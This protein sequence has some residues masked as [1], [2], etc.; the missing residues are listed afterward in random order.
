VLPLLAVVPIFFRLNAPRERW[1][2]ATAL[3]LAPPLLVLL[4]LGLRNGLAADSYSPLGMNAGFVFF[5]GNN[6]LSSGRSAVYPPL[7]GELNIEGGGQPDAP[8]LAY[9][10]VAEQSSGRALSTA[11][12]N[13]FWRRKALDFIADHPGRFLALSGS[14]SWFV[15]HEHRRH[16]L[17][18]AERYEQR[19]RALR[20]PA[21]PLAIVWPLALFGLAVSLPRWRE[22]L[23]LYAL[24]ASQTAVLVLVYV[25]ERQRLPL[26]P[27]LVFFACA[28]LTHAATA[29]RRRV[30]GLAAA[31]L[32]FAALLTRPNAV[33]RE[34][35]HVWAA[36]Q[37]REQVWQ[38]AFRLR[39]EGRLDEAAQASVLAYAAA[40]WL[41]DYSRPAGLGFLPGEFAERALAALGAEDDHPS[42]RFDR[43]QLLI[44][45]GR[46]EEAETL[47]HRLVSEGDRFDRGP[48]QSSQPLYYLARIAAVRG[49][50]EE[51][52]GYLGRALEAAPGDPFVMAE[53]SALTGDGAHRQTI[54]R[55][56]SEIEAARLTGMAQ[57][58]LGTR[59]RGVAELS[60]AVQLLPELWRTKIYLA[61]ALG[62]QGNGEAAIQ[63]YREAMAQR[64]DPA[65]LEGR[66]VPVFAAAAAGAPGGAL[67]HFQYGGVLAQFGRYDEALE[68]LRIARAFGGGQ[69]VEE[70]IAEVER[71]RLLTPP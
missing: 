13:R 45:A 7:V 10:R 34:D 54:A 40:P 3:V 6:P 50:P 65:L 18:P 28:A 62:A 16:D 15:L 44:D 9:R 60:R 38:G 52:L 11:E 21:V 41:R 25:S 31:T 46:W 12:A 49:R 51:A 32:L 36:Y 43:A 20:I 37:A 33:I 19:L 47:L 14:K 1:L 8:H 17:V 67:A 68:A 71:M 30:A 57:L 23:L 61:A 4:A 66:I 56:F 26:L 59:D 29:P 35:R 48:L 5:E 39:D 2:R 70:A 55:Y 58:E 53:L 27:C 22:L 63:R 64:N 24:L 69:E 42:R